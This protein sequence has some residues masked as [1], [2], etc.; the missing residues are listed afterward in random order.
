M[1]FKAILYILPLV[2]FLLGTPIL[3]AAQVPGQAPSTTPTTQPIASETSPIQV[4]LYGLMFLI[5]LAA[6]STYFI[7]RPTP[8][9]KKE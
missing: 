2:V 3:H 1:R 5:A 8:S 6:L 7:A 9:G 4:A